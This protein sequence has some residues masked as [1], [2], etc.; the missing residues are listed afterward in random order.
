M[1]FKA[2]WSVLLSVDFQFRLPKIELV[3]NFIFACMPMKVDIVDVEHSRPS[4]KSGPSQTA[5]VEAVV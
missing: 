1:L 4:P 5:T 2:S 3:G